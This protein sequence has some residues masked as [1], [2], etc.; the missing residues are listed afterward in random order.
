MHTLYRLLSGGNWCYHAL[1]YSVD[2]GGHELAWYY[3]VE[4]QCGNGPSWW[5]VL[6]SGVRV[7]V[8]VA[9]EYAMAGIDCAVY[10]TLKKRGLDME[11]EDHQSAHSPV[12]AYY[13]SHFSVTF[14]EFVNL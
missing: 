10:K 9:V 2:A 5:L 11:G 14:S 6:V 7:G 1:N 13:G 4:Q 3:D 12:G 8:S